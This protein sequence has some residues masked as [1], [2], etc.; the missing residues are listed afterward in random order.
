MGCSAQLNRANKLRNRGGGWKHIALRYYKQFSR[1]LS[2]ASI[3]LRARVS[4]NAIPNNQFMIDPNHTRVGVAIFDT[5]IL[6]NVNATLL[7]LLSLFFSRPVRTDPPLRHTPILSTWNRKM[8]INAIFVRTCYQRHQQIWPFFVCVCM[9]GFTL[10]PTYFNAA[11]SQL[12]N[13]HFRKANM[14]PTNIPVL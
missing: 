4:I 3:Q 5:S 12:Y 6:R 8:N 13:T 7:L 2:I 9:W 1:R 10:R 14:K 11:L